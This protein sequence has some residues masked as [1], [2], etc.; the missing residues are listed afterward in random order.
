MGQEIVIVNGDILLVGANFNGAEDIFIVGEHFV[1]FA[2]VHIS[3]YSHSLAVWKC[4]EYEVEGSRPRG[5]PTWKEV[6]QKDCQARNLNR[7]DAMDRGS[8]E[9]ADKDWMMITMV[10]G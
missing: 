1:T 3:F 7:E 6:V 8:M 5:R 2:Y 10:G 4:M 9:E